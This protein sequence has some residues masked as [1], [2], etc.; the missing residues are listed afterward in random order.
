MRCYV[1]RCEV[2]LG[3]NAVILEGVEPFDVA[4]CDSCVELAF[5]VL[6]ITPSADRCIGCGVERPAMK[7]DFLRSYVWSG[8]GP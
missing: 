5:G 7:T 2:A 4:M 1:C 6:G 3:V 8:D